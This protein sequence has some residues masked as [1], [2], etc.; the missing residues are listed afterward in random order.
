ME[1]KRENIPSI[2]II[3]DT[4]RTC[5][6]SRQSAQLLGYTKVITMDANG[7]SGGIWL[8]YDGEVINVNGEVT[9]QYARH[10]NITIKGRPQAWNLLG[11]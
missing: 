3:V 11:I 8:V 7:F 2:C 9:S 10:L 4:R 5:F 6:D 1:L